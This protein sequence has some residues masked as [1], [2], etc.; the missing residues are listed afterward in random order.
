MSLPVPRL[1][2]Q[3][4]GDV[5]WN[6]LLSCIWRPEAPQTPAWT[7]RE[8]SMSHPRV[9][10]CIFFINSLS[11]AGESSLRRS[12]LR[13]KRARKYIY[14][15]REQGNNRAN[16]GWVNEHLQ[17]TVLDSINLANNM[18]CTVFLLNYMTPSLFE[19]G[20]SVALFSTKGFCPDT[21]QHVETLQCAIVCH[22]PRAEPLHFPTPPSTERGCPVIQHLCCHAKL[23]SA[24][25]FNPTP[26][27]LHAVELFFYLK[28]IP[29]AMHPY[30]S[31]AARSFLTHLTGC[32]LQINV[33]HMLR[34]GW[35]RLFAVADVW[36]RQLWS[37]GFGGGI[38]IVTE[39]PPDLADMRNCTETWQFGFALK[40]W[41]TAHPKQAGADVALDTDGART[42]P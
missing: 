28:D 29:L 7:N 27:C 15:R 34:V 25:I 42:Q 35:G 33:G 3:R 6:S 32:L 22:L 23:L 31:W 16:N 36:E 21:I 5:T 17:I 24:P 39:P 8:I 4:H 40:A 18:F 10:A 37:K 1:L 20:G 19:T 11:Q 38:P 30:K 9:N 14:L 12:D 41:V 26:G 13:E 2:L